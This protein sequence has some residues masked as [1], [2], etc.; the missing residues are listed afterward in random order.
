MATTETDERLRW[1]EAR[2]SSSLRPRAD[3]L[4]SLFSDKENRC[5]R[6]RVSKC[7]CRWD[8]CPSRM[9]F[10]NLRLAS[11]PAVALAGSYGVL[12]RTCVA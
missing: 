7:R 5:A 2:I 10:C 1:L 11:S 6:T 9:Q 8:T 4:R 12:E 3:D